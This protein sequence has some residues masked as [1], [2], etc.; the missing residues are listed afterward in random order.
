VSDFSLGD[1]LS[2]ALA[3]AANADLISMARFRQADLQVDEKADTTPVTDADRAVE[4]SIR[5]T[6]RQARPDDQILGEERGH[7]GGTTA[8]REWVIDPIDG[9]AGFS[10]GLSIWATLIALT[11]DGIPRVGVVSAPALGFRWWAASGHGAWMRADGG[12][13]VKLQVSQTASL[14]DAIVSYN[15]LPGWMAAGRQAQLLTLV[16]K[17]WRARAIGDFWPYMLVAEGSV[18]VA[19]EWDL[20]PY[21]MAALWPIVEEAGG[22]FSALTGDRTIAQGSALATNGLLHDEVVTIVRGGD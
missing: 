8:S 7:S 22:Q 15:N 17:C 19:G 14:S 10:R 6:I 3:A 9:T 20:Q 4:D 2:L 18:D 13:P 11:I 1:D 21:D 5:T 16:S 12:S